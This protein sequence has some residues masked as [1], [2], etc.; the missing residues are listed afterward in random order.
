MRNLDMSN[1]FFSA[2]LIDMVFQKL[3]SEGTQDLEA[4]DLTLMFRVRDLSRMLLDP[5]SL[6]DEGH[7]YLDARVLKWTL[8]AMALLRKLMVSGSLPE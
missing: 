1:C 8:P 4:R 5:G 6:P 2:G 3:L 7:L